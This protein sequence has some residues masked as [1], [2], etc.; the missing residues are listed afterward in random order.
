MAVP[1]TT[2]V[3]TQDSFKITFL[4]N[5][6]TYSVKPVDDDEGEGR[7]VRFTKRGPGGEALARYLLSRREDGSLACSCPAGENGYA[8]CK[9]RR[10]LAAFLA[11]LAK[12]LSPPA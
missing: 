5:E 10:K 7:G 3:A 1:S 12:A 2:A 9:H 4:I 8:S 11:R 6:V